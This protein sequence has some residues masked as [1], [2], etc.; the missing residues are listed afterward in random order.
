M[1]EVIEVD[2]RR[3][4]C[5]LPVIRLQDTINKN[6]PGTQVRIVSTDPGSMNDIP[7]WSRING[8]QVLESHEQDKEFVFL[9]QKGDES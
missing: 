1:S 8:H 4:F 2:A 6:P 3:L 7:T 5:P 9:V